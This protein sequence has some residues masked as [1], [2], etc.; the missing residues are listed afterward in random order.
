[1]LFTLDAEH[2]ADLLRADL[3]I[4]V[5]R[6]SAQVVPTILPQSPNS[7]ILLDSSLNSAMS[8]RDEPSPKTSQVEFNGENP[9]PA[10]S[11]IKE[12]LSK[13][14]INTS[15]AAMRRAAILTMLDE[16]TATLGSLRDDLDFIEQ[17]SRV[18]QKEVD[19]IIDHLNAQFNSIDIDAELQENKEALRHHID[20]FKWFKV[21][22]IDDIEQNLE[23]GVATGY[24]IEL[25]RKVRGKLASPSIVK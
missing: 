16:C 10:L 7:L 18:L 2:A 12:Q 11:K 25:E 14:N 22:E 20:S 23:M 13:I 1:M 6:P 19:S 17:H 3:P 15:A 9:S 24:G 8:G 5:M 4:I 21:W